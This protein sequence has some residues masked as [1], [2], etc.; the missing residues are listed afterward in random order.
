MKTMQ[1]N[2]ALLSRLWA[3]LPILCALG[4]GVVQKAYE[5]R[6]VPAPLMPVEALASPRR[7]PVPP[8]DGSIWVPD[9][10]ENLFSGDKAFRKGDIVLVKVIQKNTGTKQANTDTQRKSTISAK[11]KY[12]L[13]LEKSI[14]KLTDYT[15][16]NADGTTGPWDPNDLINAESNSTFKGEGSTERSDALQA[17]VSAI[18]TDVLT[19][20]NLMIYGHQ[21]VQVNNESSVLTVQ[22]VVR[23]SDISDSNEIDSSRIANADI[24]FTGSGVLTDKQHPGWAVRVFDW[25]WPF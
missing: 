12:A 22:G 20:G 11:I 18:V 21:V 9:Q 8:T 25:V 6:P 1:E 16:K 2:R 14:N 23:P 7:A 17:T 19:N 5:P 15:N 10:S 13:G 4:C 24:Q 3:A